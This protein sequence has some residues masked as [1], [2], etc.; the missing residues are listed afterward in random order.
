M[1]AP[2]TSHLSQKGLIHMI[3]EETSIGRKVLAVVTTTVLAISGSTF[4]Q[5]SEGAASQETYE[6]GNF[7]P[8]NPN[9]AD[10]AEAGLTRVDANQLVQRYIHVLK[11]AQESGKVSAED[12]NQ[13]LQLAKAPSA[14]DSNGISTRAL[15]LW[16]AGAVVGCA[17]SVVVGEGKTQIK[18]ALKD[19]ASIDQATDIAVGAAVDCVFGA[20]PGG[21]I[22]ASLKKALTK[23]IKSA[24]KPAVKKGV[25][26]VDKE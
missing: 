7:F 18:N 1:V 19:G 26:K 16:A 21:V 15:P 2:F 8:K 13:M 12:T 10:L 17:A 9:E 25:E 4:A 20:A 11:E 14:T 3:P 6:S 22:T 24:L 23:P 5:A